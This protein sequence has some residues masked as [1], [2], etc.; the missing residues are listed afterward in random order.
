MPQ[1]LGLLY[2]VIVV[3]IYLF[4]YGITSAYF[5]KMTVKGLDIIKICH[6]ESISW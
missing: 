2:L 5:I 6:I 1:V 4:L 3:Y